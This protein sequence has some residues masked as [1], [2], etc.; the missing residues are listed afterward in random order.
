MHGEK[1]ETSGYIPINEWAE[2]DPPREKLISKGKDALSDAELLAIILGS[3]Y[4][5]K[6]AVDVA[7]NLLNEAGNDIANLR[8]YS[9]SQLK[10]HK[11][12]GSARAVN[13]IAALELG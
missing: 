11:G 12:I 13:I 5:E 1:V 4:K 9:I 8:K 3:G 6:S 7:K 10:K 2:D